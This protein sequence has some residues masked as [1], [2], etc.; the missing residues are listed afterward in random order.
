MKSKLTTTHFALVLLAAAALITSLTLGMLS[1]SA[2]DRKG[3]AH[4]VKECSQY[5]GLAGGFCT[6]TSSNLDLIPPGA[7]VYYDQAKGVPAGLL[8]S[9]VV[10]DAGDGNRA[11][12]RCT[13]DLATGKGLCTFSDGTGSFAGFKARFEVSHVG[14]P[15][16]SWDGTFRIHDDNSDQDKD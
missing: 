10:V 4:I 12:G 2:S 1:V 8:D 14:G 6:F 11:L 13:F 7:R 15:V 16:F 3:D 5:T 9:N